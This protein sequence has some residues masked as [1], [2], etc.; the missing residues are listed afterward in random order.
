MNF[1]EMVTSEIDE[2]GPIMDVEQSESEFAGVVAAGIEEVEG[3]DESH[4]LSEGSFGEEVAVT[5]DLENFPMA[6][7]EEFLIAETVCGRDDRVRI[8]P[9]TGTPWRWICQLIITR[10]DGG[11][12]RCTGWFIGPRTV[13]TSGHCVFSRAAGGWA[14]RI[15]VIPGMNAALRPFGSQVATSFRSVLGWTRDQ[16][17]NYD[18]GAIILPNNNLGNRVGWFGFANLS[19]GSLN[20][21]L[22]NNAGYPGD[23][24]FGTQWFNAG[25]ITKVNDHLLEYMIDT[26]SGQNGSPIWRYSNGQRQAVGVHGYGGCPNKAM[27]INRSVFDNMLAWKQLGL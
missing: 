24:P 27:R 3:F 9:T 1:H 16:N 12:S 13:M 18:Y 20:G 17:Q 2:L 19:T 6:G 10:A 23:K 7:A 11:Q 22:V 4:A 15:E 8:S 14:R 25:R 26:A 5:D 21:L